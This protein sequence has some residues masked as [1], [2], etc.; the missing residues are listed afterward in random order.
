MHTEQ[1]N[2]SLPDLTSFMFD[3]WN[4]GYTGELV[5]NYICIMSGCT[6]QEANNTIKNVYDTM[7][8]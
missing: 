6:I 4:L 5:T 2:T 3:A 1:A 7:K 8:E